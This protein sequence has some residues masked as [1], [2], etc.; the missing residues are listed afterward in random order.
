MNICSYMHSKYSRFVSVSMSVCL[1]VCLG[2]KSAKRGG[3]GRE[4]ILQLNRIDCRGKYLAVAVAVNASFAVA[5]V[6]VVLLFL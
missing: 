6:T 5:L 3:G 1:F 4:G 2:E